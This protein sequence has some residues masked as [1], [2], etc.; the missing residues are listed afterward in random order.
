M[1][2]NLILTL[3]LLA[4]VGFFGGLA[5]HRLKFPRVTGY[6]II[7]ILLSPSLTGIISEPTIGNLSIFTSIALGIIAYSIGGS[8]H[9][10]KI[11]QLESSIAWITPLQALGTWLITTFII[12]LVAPFILHISNYDGGSS[13]D[14]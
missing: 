12:T 6:I 4:I 13:V 10:E 11:K 8:L 9:L 3:G 2:T 14:W 1:I 5:A 7:G